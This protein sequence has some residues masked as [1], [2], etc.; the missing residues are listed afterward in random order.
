MDGCSWCQQM[1]DVQVP[2]DA[3]SSWRSTIQAS[4]QRWHDAGH[5]GVIEDLGTFATPSGAAEKLLAG[6]AEAERYETAYYPF[7]R[8]DDI[9][10]AAL[11]LQRLRITIEWLLDA[12]RTSVDRLRKRAEELDAEPRLHNWHTAARSSDLVAAVR[13]LW[14]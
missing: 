14:D 11:E 6:I 13:W 10:T 3:T 2:A 4:N 12:Q 5:P 1:F 7:T 8:E 9:K